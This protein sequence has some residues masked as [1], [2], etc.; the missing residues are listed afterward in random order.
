VRAAGA[1]LQARQA[2]GIKPRKPLV[3]S[4]RVSASVSGPSCIVNSL[5]TG[6][7]TFAAQVSRGK[8][9]ILRTDTA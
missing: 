8:D 7:S 6:E 2:L 9:G 1:I 4:T 3:R 5:C